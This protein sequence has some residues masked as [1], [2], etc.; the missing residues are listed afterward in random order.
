MN[1]AVDTAVANG[2]IAAEG[3]ATVRYLRHTLETDVMR[4]NIEAGKQCTRLTMT[5]GGKISFVLTEGLVM[6]RIAPLDALK[7]DM[8]GTNENDDG[9]FDGNFMLMAGELNNSSVRLFRR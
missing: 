8:D 3:K 6:K 2:K 9:R 1:H 5:W 4:H 7:E